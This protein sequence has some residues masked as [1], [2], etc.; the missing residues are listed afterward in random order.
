MVGTELMGNKSFINE[1]K[2][3]LLIGLGFMVLT[4]WYFWLASIA[5]INYIYKFI[6][7]M[8]QGNFT[9]QLV[10]FDSL[11][12]Y[13]QMK[14]GLFG[15]NY[16]AIAPEV[17]RAYEERAKIL[18]YVFAVEFIL[19]LTIFLVSGG[20][21]IA[22]IS[23]PENIVIVYSVFQ[24]FVLLMNIIL[25]IYLFITGFSI[26]F[27][28]YI[29]GGEIHRFMRMTH[30]LVGIA[31]IPTWFM[32]TVIAFKDHKY[33]SR[34]SSNLFYKIFLKGSYGHMDR[35][36]YYSYVAFGF[37]LVLSGFVIWFFSLEASTYADMIQFKRLLLFIHFMGSA[38]ISFFI[39][40]TIYSAVVSVK[41]YLP[42]LITGKL[43]QE[44]IDQ[45]RPDLND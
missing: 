22:K 45:I 5:D 20:R 41:G 28:H 30:E 34:P 40:E 7:Q 37:L 26:T 13:E 36:N 11:N 16:T 8:L 29:G 9:G 31:W 38:I 44:Y 43:P 15:P 25:M 33:F 4:Y 10:P 21:R 3:Y 27:G 39:F 18:P 17:I 32:L 2:A 24:R 19:F 23:N 42:S 35:I 12:H 1:Y 6:L 14:V